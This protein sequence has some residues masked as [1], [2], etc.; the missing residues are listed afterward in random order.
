MSLKLKTAINSILAGT[1]L[2]VVSST[3]FASGAVGVQALSAWIGSNNVLGANSEI[4]TINTLGLNKNA[5]TDNAAL[6]DSSWGHTGKWF[7]FDVTAANQTVDINATVLTGNASVA[8]TVWASGNSAF[9]GGTT[10]PG[11]LSAV[12]NAPHVFN[13]VGQLG[14]AGTVWATDPSVNAAG[15]GN[16]LETLAYVNT[17]IAHASGSWGEV[18]NAGVNQVAADNTYFSGTVAGGTTSNSADL[19]FQNLAQGFYAIYVGGADS[20]KTLASTYQLSI[21]AVPVPG[22]VYL[23]GSALAGMLACGR[24]KLRAV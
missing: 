12:G 23:F 9:N 20:S 4:Q 24:K 3:S 5:F 19:V 7:T 6:L 2:S 15:G 10:A 13:S 11:E 21:S 22:A 16:L 18:I 8:F 17:G 1:V 14:S